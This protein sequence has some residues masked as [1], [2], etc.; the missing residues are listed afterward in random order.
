[1]ARHDQKKSEKLFI[2]DQCRYNAC[3]LCPDVLLAAIGRPG[4]RC[5]CRRERHA[6]TLADAWVKGGKYH[7]G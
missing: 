2:C 6:K 4:I 1:M 3:P 7:R 5:L